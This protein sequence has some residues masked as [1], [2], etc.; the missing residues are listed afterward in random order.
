VLRRTKGGSVWVDEVEDEEDDDT[1][2]YPYPNTGGLD[3]AGIDARERA[4]MEGEASLRD[5]ASLLITNEIQWREA[6]SY[7]VGARVLPEG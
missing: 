4:R 1:S 5:D 2:P 3:A 7:N 6:F